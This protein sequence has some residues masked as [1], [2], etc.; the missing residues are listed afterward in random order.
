[1]YEAAALIRA[2]LTGATAFMRGVDALDER[3]RAAG[4]KLVV[5]HVWC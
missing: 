4:T 2:A 3:R 1:V 5:A